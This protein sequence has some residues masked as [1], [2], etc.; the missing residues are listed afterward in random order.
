MRTAH[1][2]WRLDRWRYYSLE[3]PSFKLRK[4]V[5]GRRA[6][7]LRLDLFALHVYIVQLEESKV[8]RCNRLVLTKDSTPDELEGCGGHG[9][10]RNPSLCQIIADRMDEHAVDTEH[11]QTSMTGLLL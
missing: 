2:S 3:P 6:H 10:R 7:F 1:S 8:T 9:S 11:D 5:L 4:E